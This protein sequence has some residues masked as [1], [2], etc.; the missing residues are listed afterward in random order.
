[1]S[2]QKNV[3]IGFSDILLIPFLLG[4]A[5]IGS[6]L[7]YFYGVLP[8]GAGVRTVMP[9]A[10]VLLICY[11]WYVVKKGDTAVTDRVLGGLWAG[12]IATL[13]Y[14]IVRVPIVWTGVPVF[15]AISYFGTVI[16]DE[17]N[18]TLS[19]EIAGWSYHY[20]NGIGF[21]LMYACLVPRARW[22]TAI[23]WGMFLEA[24]MLMT[25]YAEVFGY[26][27]TGKFF[28]ITIGSH[29]VYGL[30]LWLGLRYWKSARERNTR[31]DA[32]ESRSPRLVFS[33]RGAVVAWGLVVSTLGIAYVGADFHG[34]HSQSIPTSP[35]AYL[36]SHLY[37]T[38]NVL[39]PDRV[40]ALWVLKR[41]INPS[42][43]FHFIEPFSQPRYG[44]PFD[45]PEANTRRTGSHSVTRVLV[46]EHDLLQNDHLALLSKM[47]DIFEIVPWMRAFDPDAEVLGRGLLQIVGDE[48]ETVKS[49]LERGFRYLDEWY[50]SKTPLG[51]TA[52]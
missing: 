1:M 49:R 44:K 16:L 26:R 34:R 23:S 37:T 42:A 46:E 47:A 50:A 2:D 8:M 19:T 14:D 17:P 12:A 7:L 18:V 13:F 41:H 31:E 43:R 22:W 35:P 45:I 25:P 20:S 51:K 40:A 48:Q 52:P 38:W 21:G 33:P 29:A 15:K 27:Y 10:V 30:C 39:E 28:L 32:G 36:G 6:L 3:R 24:A 5:S 4:G 9:P 11:I